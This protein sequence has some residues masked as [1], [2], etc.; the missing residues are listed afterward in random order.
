MKKAGDKEG[1]AGGAEDSANRSRQQER[2]RDA[3]DGN[4]KKKI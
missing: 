3:F 1:E 4:H 2:K